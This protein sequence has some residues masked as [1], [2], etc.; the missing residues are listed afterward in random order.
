[1]KTLIDEVV[2]PRMERVE[3]VSAVNIYGGLERELHVTF[4]PEIL[5]SS[6]ITI[7]E[8]IATLRSA[9]RDLPG[10]AFSEGKRR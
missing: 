1:M 7:N 8:L 6:G 10:G 9:N 4:Y 5:A 2:K 3:G